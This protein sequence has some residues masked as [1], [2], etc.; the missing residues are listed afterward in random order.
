MC[1]VE[2][3][4]YVGDRRIIGTVGSHEMII[5]QEHENRPWTVGSSS[6]LPSNLQ[7]AQEYLQCMNDAFECLAFHR[8]RKPNKAQLPSNY[9]VNAGEGPR[10]P[11]GSAAHNTKIKNKGVQW[12]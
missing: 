9:T 8:S 2:I 7:E 5:L 3:E 11:D 6:T 12:S 1:N 10:F 4:G